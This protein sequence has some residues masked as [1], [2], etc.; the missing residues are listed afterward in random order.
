MATID[1]VIDLVN[2]YHQGVRQMLDADSPEAT[3]AILQ[4]LINMTEATPNPGNS[5]NYLAAIDDA[6][7]DL[8]MDLGTDQTTADMEALEQAWNQYYAYLRGHWWQ[9]GAD[10]ERVAL[11]ELPNA[12][13]FS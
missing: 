10:D 6:L 8:M 2:A 12:P 5:Y 4:D 7:T 13:T 3:Q 9:F 1:N 11:Y